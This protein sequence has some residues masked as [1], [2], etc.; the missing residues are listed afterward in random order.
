MNKINKLCCQHCGEEN[1]NYFKFGSIDLINPQAR[2]MSPMMQ[3]NYE[4]FP[5]LPIGFY[6]ECS[7][8]GKH[9]VII[10]NN[11]EHREYDNTIPSQIIYVPEFKQPEYSAT[12]Y[13]LRDD[14][15]LDQIVTTNNGE[16]IS[17][18]TRMPINVSIMWREIDKFTY[19]TCL[20][21]GFKEVS[22]N[23]RQQIDTGNEQI[24]S[25]ESIKSNDSTVEFNATNTTTTNETTSNEYESK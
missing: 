6:F 8:C 18:I 7:K 23:V 5:K 11:Y 1:P 9:T 25:T 20:K 14:G 3:Q 13:I 4:W 19:E 16:L 17:L 15:L 10:P 24:H 12:K 21:N 22:L 2:M